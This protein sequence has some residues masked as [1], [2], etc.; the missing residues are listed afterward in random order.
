[1]TRSFEQR[2]SGVRAAA[3]RIPPDAP[4]ADRGASIVARVQA[5]VHPG[6]GYT[7]NDVSVSKPIESLG[8][9]LLEPEDCLDIAGRGLATQRAGCNFSRPGVAACAISAKDAERF[10]VGGQT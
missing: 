9:K 2:T 6:V 1:M 7:S 8:K 4:E 3:Y 10:K 5:G